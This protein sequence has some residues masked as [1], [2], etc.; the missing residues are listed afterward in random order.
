MPTFD[1]T[2][3]YATTVDAPLTQVYDALLATDFASHPVVALLMGLRSIPAF[4]AAPRAALQRLRTVRPAGSL[5]LETLLSQD[6]ALL[7]E[8][9]PSELVLGLTGRFWTPSGGLVPTDPAT[10]RQLP[11]TGMARAAWNF[12]LEPLAD[13]RT[14]LSTETR[15]RCGDAATTRRFRMYWRLVA[16]GSGVIRWAILSMVRRRAERGGHSRRAK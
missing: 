6:F 12:A 7:Q 5:E 14:R 16:P 11:P 10:F 9:P 8:Q 3:V 1:V 13:G 2:A 15:V 4:V